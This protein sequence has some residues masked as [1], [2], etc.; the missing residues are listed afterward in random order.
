MENIKEKIIELKKKKNAIILAHYYQRD[1][2]QEIADFVGDS[3]ELSRRAQKNDADIILFC[4]V[5]FMAETAKILSPE[6]KV[7]LAN[8]K[9]GCTMA[10][11]VDEVALKEYLEKDPRFVVCYINSYASVK[12]ISDVCVTSANAEKIVNNFKDKKILYI[13]DK[14]LGNYLRTKYDL[15]LKVW[16]GYCKIHDEL[17]IRDLEI[18][19][20]LHPNA[21]VIVHPEA[22]LDILERADHVSSTKGMFDF[23]AHDD[24]EEYIIGTEKGVLYQMKKDYPNKKFYILSD[25]LVC[26]DMKKTTL[27][28]VYNT[29]DQEINEINLDEEIRKKAARAI[30]RMLEL[31]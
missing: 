15:D 27:E 18:K 26:P 7:L 1:E 9:A 30:E 24:G 12:A 19:K 13:P 31:S 4:G 20:A 16:P 22:Q 14:N 10:K 21:K 5:N 25:R 3:L 17:S 6:K 28:D 11:M 23:L 2:I 8:G 29:L